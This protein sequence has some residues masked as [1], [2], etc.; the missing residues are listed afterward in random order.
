MRLQ[1]AVGKAESSNETFNNA[2]EAYNSQF[3][4]VNMF[5]QR[6]SLLLTSYEGF[7]VTKTKKANYLDF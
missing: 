2:P 4:Y 7:R 3:L 5:I 1:E 6:I